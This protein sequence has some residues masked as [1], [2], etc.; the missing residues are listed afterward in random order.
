MNCLAEY[1]S[2]LKLVNVLMELK[3][4]VGNK[5]ARMQRKVSLLPLELKGNQ[6]VPMPL[7]SLSHSDETHAKN[8]VKSIKS[9]T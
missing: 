5:G 4:I 2:N 8:K 7:H 9:E 6:T 3:S 1:V